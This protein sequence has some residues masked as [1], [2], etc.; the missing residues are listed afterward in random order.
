LESYCAAHCSPALSGDLL[1]S[2][3]ARTTAEMP[4][5]ANMLSDALVGAVLRA[6]VHAATAHDSNAAPRIL[7]LGTFTG[8]STSWLLDCLP[9]AFVSGELEAALGTRG[10]VV[11]CELRDEYAALARE[12][13]ATHPRIDAL[14]LRVGPAI[15]TLTALAADAAAPA[16][17]STAAFDFIYIDANKKAS[18]RYVDAILQLGLLKRPTGILLIDN[19]L[20]KG[21]VVHAAAQAANAA[22]S[23]SPDMATLAAASTGPQVDS[24]G[25]AIHALNVRLANDPRLLVTVL[26]ARDGLTIVQHRTQHS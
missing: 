22:S 24:M 23:S 21:Q 11:S 3:A 17:E 6:L 8:Y 12:N 13:L 4:E 2:I 1:Q 19:T 16:A 20:W 26:P 14:D 9:P 18:A 10:V 7:E 15:D 25:R 5:R